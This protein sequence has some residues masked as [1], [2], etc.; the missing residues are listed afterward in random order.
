LTLHC[1]TVSFRY[2]RCF[3]IFFRRFHYAII[4]G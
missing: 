4:D 2:Y 1:A 3:T